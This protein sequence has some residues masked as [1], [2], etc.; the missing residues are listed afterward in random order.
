[1]TR[2]VEARG[3]PILVR[4]GFQRMTQV[5]VAGDIQQVITAFTKQQISMET[6]GS[7]L[8]LSALS[9]TSPGSCS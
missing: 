5:Q 7:R 9:P 3:E 2:A 6:T 8:F 4:L 1:M